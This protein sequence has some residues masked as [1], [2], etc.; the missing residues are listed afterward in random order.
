MIASEYFDAAVSG[1]DPIDDRPGFKAL[2]ER[3]ASNGVRTV[4]VEDASRFARTLMV[5][6]AGIAIL[7][8]MGVRVL[9]S[10][11]DDLTDSDDEM[12]VAMR[13]IAGVFSQLEK[14]RLV[15]KLKAARDRRR[16]TGAR[17]EGRR[18]R[19]QRLRD[20]KATD[21]VTNLEAAVGLAKRLR[22]ASP[23]TGKRMSL[24]KISAELAKAGH[25]NEQG[26]PYNPKSVLGRSAPP[27]RPPVDAIR[28]D[29][30]LATTQLMQGAVRAAQRILARIRRAEAQW[31]LGAHPVIRFADV[32][33]AGLTSL[34]F[35]VPAQVLY[36]HLNS[37]QKPASLAD[38]LRFMF[39]TPWVLAI[40]FGGALLF[41]LF[42]LPDAMRVRGRNWS[43]FYGDRLEA[44][45]KAGRGVER[46]EHHDA[47]PLPEDISAHELFGLT[48]G[49]TKSQLRA[50]WLRLAREL[51]PD[52]WSAAAP[53]ARKMKEAALQRVNA[54]RDELAPL[55]L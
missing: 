45:L 22:R 17:V 52:R 21:A 16:A 29:Y 23:V 6:E 18:S 20:A 41:S 38:T 2:I 4:I 42:V 5:Q 55:A 27:A 30:I 26:R 50:A 44:A 7:V 33:W 15:K 47:P 40:A 54:A 3:I 46:A 24:R 25:L 8:S 36:Y 32:A 31:R 37:R 35:T 12:R 49:F 28:A 34:F 53:A 39:E 9:T 43:E 10:R 48:P 13:Q 51:H 11:G 14:T 1:A 19:L